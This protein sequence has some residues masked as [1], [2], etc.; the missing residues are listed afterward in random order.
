MRPRIAVA[1]VASVYGSGLMQGLVVVS[2]PASGAVL[3]AAHGLSDAQYGALFLVQTVLAIVG[4]VLAGGLAR[5]LGLPLLA[6]AAL[7]AGAGAEGLLVATPTLGPA[8]A[9]AAI[10]AAIGL[11]GLG[12]GLSSAPLNSYP[13]VLFPARRE[14]ALVVLHTL[15]GAGFAVGP[16]LAGAAMDAGAWRLFPSVLAAAAAGLA[17][18]PFP[19]G[20]A[21]APATAA[22]A[23]AGPRTSAAFWSLAAAAVIY[24]LCEGTFGSWIVIYLQEERAVAPANAAVALST[25]WGALVAGRLLVSALV[26]RVP[27]R[28]IWVALPVL[29]LVAFWFLPAAHDATSGIALFALAGLAC[30]AFFP[31]TVGFASGRFARDVAWV[32]SMLTA[33][34]ML[35]SGLG[36]FA[37]GALRRLTSL[38]ALYRWSSIYAIA[39][40]ALVAVI[41]ASRSPEPKGELS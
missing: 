28:R 3:K 27:S 10:L 20:E 13:G 19:G 41:T 39:L 36:S 29:M 2:F 32:S 8:A 14:S 26:V 34:L 18:M 31:L 23:A 22:P 7:L 24:A 40:L 12:F 33:S 37:L 5:R 38:A 25:F 30:S 11:A 9:Y 4:S 1:R 35:G 15:I 17:L 6:R 16:L 21:A